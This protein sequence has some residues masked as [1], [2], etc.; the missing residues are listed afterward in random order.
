MYNNLGQER[1]INEMNKFKFFRILPVIPALFCTSCT[2]HT[3]SNVEDYFDILKEAREEFDFHSQLYLYPDTIENT[4]IVTFLYQETE[5]LFTGS[6][7]FYLV[8]TYSQEGFDAEL[9]RMNNVKAE[10]KNGVVKPALAYPDLNAFLTISKD[11]RYEYALYDKE[12]LEIAYISNQL[13][14]WKQLTI[15][16]ERHYMPNFVIPKEY[17]D[18]ENT[19]NM[20]YYFEDNVG[21]EI[22]RDL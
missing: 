14:S 8:L 18:G 20:Y 15:L 21:Y 2:T 6:Y 19:Y 3:K 12:K 5:D 13:Y 7:F 1:C 10:Y 16:E 4:E 11:N 9:E 22:G 17:D